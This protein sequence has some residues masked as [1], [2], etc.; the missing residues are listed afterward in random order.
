M[1]AR[2][3]ENTGNSSPREFSL[4]VRASTFLCLQIDEWRKKNERTRH[5]VFC[6]LL[7]TDRDPSPPASMIKSV[8][9]DS[10]IWRQSLM[11]LGPVGNTVKG[12]GLLFI[13][14]AKV[15]TNY[16]F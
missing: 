4:N 14:G 9:N 5:R 7:T 16:A 10:A 13:S 2:P 8:L 3:G 6:E 12:E 15:R 1:T 11:L